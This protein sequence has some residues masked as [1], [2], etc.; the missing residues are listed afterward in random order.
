[1]VV[2]QI[3]QHQGQRHVI[4][5]VGG[6]QAESA[7]AG[8]AFAVRPHHIMLPHPAAPWPQPDS[9]ATRPPG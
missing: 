3:D 7:H 4:S 9:H 8:E 2:L 5:V 1:V 6:L